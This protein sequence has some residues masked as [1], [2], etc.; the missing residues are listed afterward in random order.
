MLI[1]KTSDYVLFDRA[2]WCRAAIDY[3]SQFAAEGENNFQ[4]IDIKRARYDIN[5][6]LH[7][8]SS[9]EENSSKLIM[10]ENLLN[11]VIARIN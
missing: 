1:E 8:D 7:N 5:N 11:N 6:I 4:G 9:A 3:V 10:L 2:R